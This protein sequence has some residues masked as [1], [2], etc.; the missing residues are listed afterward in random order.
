MLKRFT[1]SLKRFLY[2]FRKPMMIDG[3]KTHDGKYLPKVRISSSTFIDN[4]NRLELRDNIFIGHHNYIEASNT[5][6]IGEGCQ[7]TNF[8]TITSHSSHQSIRLY[9]NSYAGSEMKG[10][11]KGPVEIGDF[12]FI[13]PHVTIM[14]L[15]KIGKGC[16]VSSHS[17]VEGVFPDF[18][19]IAG[20]PAK[21]IGDVRTK[22]D[23]LLSEF[24]E[25]QNTYMQ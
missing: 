24:P 4:P 6:K 19:I 2:S 13:G 23:L 17:Y 18:S 3:Y 8:V 11:I 1:R 12:T 14:P 10:Y 7:I 22:D 9:G 25:L 16:V 21:V 5:I 20:I 15:T